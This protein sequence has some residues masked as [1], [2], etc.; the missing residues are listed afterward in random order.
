MAPRGT[1]RKPSSKSSKRRRVDCIGESITKVSMTM[2]N[3][4]FSKQE[5]KETN[6]VFSPL[7]IHAVLS[8]IAAGSKGSTKHQLLEFLQSESRKQLKS[9]SSQLVNSVLSDA[10]PA[11]G[12]RVSFVNGVWVQ[13]SLSFRRS[14]K[15]VA[16]T[17]FKANIASVDFSKDAEVTNELNLWAEKETN[18]LIK[19]LLP[20][21]SVNSSTRL[22]FAN[23][24]YF[25][26][27]WSDKFDASLTKD[28]DFHLLNDSTVKVPFMRSYKK[29]FIQAYDSFK[30]LRLPYAQGEDKREFSMYIFL[31]DAKDGL[32]ALVEK[33]ASES[34]LL[35]DK[36]RDLKY[37]V[38]VKVGYFRIPRFKIS[39]ELEAGKILK[40]LGLVLPFCPGG[41]NKMVDSCENLSVT[42]IFHKSFIEVNEEGTEAAAATFARMAMGISPPINFVANHPFLYLIREDLTGTVI[43]VG[44]VLNPLAE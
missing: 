44:Q 2:A 13:Q 14:F 36:L 35:D 3:H 18:G 40:E 12:P 28:D 29:Q 43:F 31:P 38:V 4:L 16:A 7:S 15:K 25:K 19:E 27:A 30:I 6:I 9:L 34:E 37:G 11:G 41:F 24:L 33:L 26:G 32:S 42:N 1:K 22:V 39:F 21:G 17:C 20:T 23:A 5:Y 8:M 10:S